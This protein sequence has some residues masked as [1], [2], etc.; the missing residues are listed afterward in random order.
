MSSTIINY[1]RLV[2]IS[3]IFTI[4]SNISLGYFLFTHTNNIDYLDIIQLISISGF[5]YIG[6]MASNDYFDIKID[7]KERPWRPLPSDKISQKNALMIILLSFSYSLIFSFILGPNTFILTLVMISLILLYNKFL[8]NTIFGA[9]NMGVIRSL[10]I[11]LG[12]SETIFVSEKQIFDIQFL[13]PVFA[14]FF[15][16]SAI[17]ILSKNETKEYSLNFSNIFPFIIIYLLIFFIAMFIIFNFLNFLSLIPLLIFLTTIF[18]SQ[19]ILLK[20]ITTVQKSISYLIMMIVFLD[21]IFLTNILGI[22][23]GIALSILLVIPMI[24]L[25]RRIYMT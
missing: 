6:G 13:I 7:R 24:F 19:I 9:V 22:Y 5:L 15:Y 2:R 11:I 23:Y 8:K 25:S 10:N 18:Y 3:N 17:T 20:K 4:V 21:S 14:E 16:I 1:L 12:A